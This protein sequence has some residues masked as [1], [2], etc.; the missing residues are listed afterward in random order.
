[1]KLDEF[2]PGDDPLAM[3][4]DP[5]QAPP[6]PAPRQRGRRRRIVARV[7]A[8]FIVVFILL[9]G[10]L[11][12]T[13]PLS[14]SLQP[15]VPP[16]MTLLSSDGQVIARRGATIDQP[17]DVTRL[18][19]HVGQAFI[20]IEDRRFRSH[21]G[22][23][24]RGIV[25]AAWNNMRAGGVRQGG[26]TITQQLAKLVFLN[27][28]RSIVRKAREAM[29]AFWLE[30]WL[31][32]DEI[33]SR[34]L[35]NVYYGDNVYGLRAAAL[36]YFSKDPEDL[37]I[38]EAAMLAG[39]MK[40][41]SRLAPSSNLAGARERAALVVGAMAEEQYLTPAQARAVRP[42]RL[43]LRSVREA[44]SGT[45]FADWVLPDARRTVEDAYAEQRVATTLDA[46]LQRY[47]ERAVR[48][49]GLGKAQVALIAMKPDGTVVAMIGGRR[50]AD[51]SFNRATQA[52]RQPGSTFKLFVYLA[53]LRSGMTPDDMIDDSPVT[54]AGWSPKNSDGRY[55]GRITLREAFARSS[56]VTAARLAQ[57][58]GPDAVIKAARDLGIASPLSDNATIAL[59]SSEITLIE[60][61]SAYAAVAANS[62]PVHAHGLPP[63]ERGWIDR[64]WNRPR[65]FG[66]GT[67]DMLLD[68]LSAT[69]NQGTGHSAALGT[70]VFGKTGTSQDNRD[71][72]FVGFADGL[73]T[74]V[75]VGNDDNSPL[76]GV[77]GGGLPARI[78]RS[79]M[80]NALGETSRPRE[81]PRREEVTDEIDAAIGDVANAVEGAIGNVTITIPTR[82]GELPV[83]IPPPPPEAEP[84]EDTGP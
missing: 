17:V 47:A 69:V 58:L 19:A 46:R 79:F 4:A 76:R 63:A 72:I 42:A 34:Y 18:P 61:A 54:I 83:L 27:A 60:L 5:R 50:Y 66:R 44:P 12:L 23:D 22:I 25:R 2:G 36:H 13:A 67:H 28:D 68:L 55:R 16:S 9:V 77:A 80:A 48:N 41:P 1:M 51:S 74:A 6:P 26:S 62:Y 82:D 45:Y 65:S 84:A 78:W 8:G 56:N 43:R 64:L 20:A 24:P 30:A 15:P 71:A 39:L 32:K 7:A 40:A 75:W 35:S 3:Q 59:G 11:A 38:G 70:Q 52:R 14:K 57:Q 81:R 31:S 33:L 53:A 49:S 73:V 29:I 37:S 10:W 21:W